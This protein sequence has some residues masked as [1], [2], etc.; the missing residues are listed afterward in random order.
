[1][2]SE[3]K[4]RRDEAADT[5]ERL[6]LQF[7]NLLFASIIIIFLFPCVLCSR[8][9]NGSRTTTAANARLLVP[10]FPRRLYLHFSTIPCNILL[11]PPI[12]HDRAQRARRRW[13]SSPKSNCVAI[14]LVNPDFF[15]TICM[16]ISLLFLAFLIML[17]PQSTCMHS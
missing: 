9:R 16:K 11:F 2:R 7:T 17:C 6:L 4:G 1:M 15:R 14:R 10:N 5:N 13:I 8:K 3:K 12:P